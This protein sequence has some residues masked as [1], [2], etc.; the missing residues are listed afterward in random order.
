LLSFTHVYVDEMH[1]HTVISY[2][3]IQQRCVISK[4]IISYVMSQFT[5]LGMWQFDCH[6][7]YVFLIVAQVTLVDKC[8]IRL[9]ELFIFT[10]IFLP[11]HPSFLVYPSNCWWPLHCSWP[12]EYWINWF[13]CTTE[14]GF[15]GYW[16]YRITY[17]YI[18]LFKCEHL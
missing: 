15:W 9:A 14:H 17:W 1:K 4:P 16:R 11:I 13:C 5:I 7:R 2:K 6:I 10:I 3:P 12:Q 18:L 8:L